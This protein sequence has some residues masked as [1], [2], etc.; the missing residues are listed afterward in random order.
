MAFETVARELTNVIEKV[1]QEREMLRSQEIET[2]L[3]SA[4]TRIQPYVEATRHEVTGNWEFY[5]TV[6]VMA[7]FIASII[8]R[9]RKGR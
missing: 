2:K 3:R 9:I 6:S 7:L 8:G 4:R 1:R 5:L